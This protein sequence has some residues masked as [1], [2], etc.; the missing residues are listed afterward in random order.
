MGALVPVL[1]IDLILVE[2]SLNKETNGVNGGIYNKNKRF[3]PNNGR[4]HLSSILSIEYK[5]RSTT[6][7]K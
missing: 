2:V 7:S 4:K 5:K 1:L 3:G 6:I